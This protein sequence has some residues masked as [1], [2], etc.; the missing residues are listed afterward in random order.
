MKRIFLIAT[1]ISGVSISVLGTTTTPYTHSV[2]IRKSTSLSTTPNSDKIPDVQKSATPPVIFDADFTWICAV[3]SKRGEWK[4]ALGT[5]ADD[6]TDSA[7]RECGSDCDYVI[8]C[9][10]YGCVAVAE[11]EH[12]TVVA[13]AEHH[14]TRTL[15]A[16]AAKKKALDTCEQHETPCTVSDAFCS[17]F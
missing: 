6:A 11:A 4:T 10:N 17:N 9:A 2:A 12:Y 15:D 7:L 3:A 14:L 13:E 8:E 1:V 16:I 5:S